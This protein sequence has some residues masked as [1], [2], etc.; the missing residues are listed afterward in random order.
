MTKTLTLKT[1]AGRTFTLKVTEE[2]GR[3]VV[4]LAATEYGNLGD[5]AELAA[6]LGPILTGYDA[7]PRPLVMA[8]PHSGEVATITDVGA[9]IRGPTLQ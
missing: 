2:P 5:E 9:I 7:D 1:K 4:D 6:W 3:V 8:N